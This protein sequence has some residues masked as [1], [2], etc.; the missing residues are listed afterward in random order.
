MKNL[1]YYATKELSQD[2]FLR[3]LFENYN[4]ENE[5]VRLACRKLFESFTSNNGDCK[6]DF[7][8]IV[9][10]ETVAQWKNIDIIVR[11]E[12]DGKDYIIAIEDKTESNEHNQLEIYN[13]QLLHSDVESSNIFKIFY[14]TNIID[15]DERQRVENQGWKI[16]DI[17]DIVQLFGNICATNEVLMYYIDYLNFIIDS[18]NRTTTP[19]KWNLNAWHSFYNDYKTHPLIDEYKEIGCYQKAYYYMALFFKNH[20]SDMPCLEIR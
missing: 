20:R 6:L 9:R 4:C 14:K 17:Y 3:W 1:F 2:A 5:S 12:I 15:L 11:F 18:L 7:N 10:L 8:K 13:K 19:D 16:Y